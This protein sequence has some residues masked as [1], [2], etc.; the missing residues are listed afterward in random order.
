MK[1]LTKALEKKLPDLSRDIS[2]PKLIVKLFHPMSNWTWYIA[3]Y[4]PKTKECFGLVD[5][6]EREWGYFS[7]AELEEIRVHGLPIERDMWFAPCHK[8]DLKD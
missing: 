7:L 3:Q 5:G 1:L 6:F 8:E 4:D 2:N